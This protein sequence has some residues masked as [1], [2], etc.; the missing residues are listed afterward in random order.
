MAELFDDITRIVGSNISRRH[1]L[2]LI[3]SAFIGAAMGTRGAGRKVGITCCNG[4]GGIC[5]SINPLTCNHVRTKA[6]C[7]AAHATWA[8][9]KRCCPE[10][11][12]YIMC[13]SDT[14]C[15]GNA[16][17][18]CPPKTIVCGDVCCVQERCLTTGCCPDD[19][20]VCAGKCCEAGKW[21]CVY[22]L[23]GEHRNTCYTPAKPSTAGCCSNGK[24]CWTGKDTSTCLYC[25]GGTT[26]V[27]GDGYICVNNEC[28][29]R[30]PTPS[31]PNG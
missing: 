2:R 10:D 11:G 4:A 30:N 1:A 9:N 26:H 5:A 17:C 6:D 31:R 13:P 15:C 23:A 16:C 18:V 3:S 28:T 25:L 22:E 20:V 7:L 14:V 29:P 24:N 27:Q 8:D 19:S 12:G 21:C